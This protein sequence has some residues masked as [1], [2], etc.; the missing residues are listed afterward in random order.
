MQMN[1]LFEIV[2]ILLNKKTITARELAERFE[3]SIRTIYRDIESLSAAGIPV[4]MSKGKGGGIKLLDNFVLNKSLLSN[5]EQKEI[6]ATLQE[7]DAMKLGN[8]DKALSKLGL[9]FNKDV[10]NWIEVD[11]SSWG[12]NNSQKFEQIKR[13]ILNQQV[14]R[15]EYH[16]SNG[17]KGVRDVEPY[18]LWFKDKTWYLRGFCRKRMEI[19]VFK[20]TR[21]KNP[22]VL[23]EIFQRQTDALINEELKNAV[24][25]ENINLKL[26]ISADAAYRVYDD[27]D[28]K[29][30]IKNSDGSFIVNV[31][32]PLDEWV[33]GYIMSY[34]KQLEVLEPI[35]LRE[36]IKRRIEET[37][38]KYI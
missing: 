17:E 5:D 24:S 18:Q 20:L 14:I 22:C 11:F 38:N 3:V 7:I 25:Y 16:N 4:Y 30:I 2:Y 35:F 36:E 9:L 31:S 21:I 1:R 6:L 13:S 28:E 8:V 15:F 19:R 37:L 12:E 10:Q 34:G 33:Y 27:F 26:Y 29:N 23:E 32:F